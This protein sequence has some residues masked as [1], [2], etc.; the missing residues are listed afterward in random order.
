[1]ARDFID[2]HAA[3]AQFSGPDLENLG[4]RH[5]EDF[6]LQELHDRL[7]GIEYISDVEFEAYGIS[8]VQIA[9]IRRWASA[10]QTS[11]AARLAAD[12]RDEAG[13]PD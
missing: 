10:W 13:Q 4:G 9:L 8:T 11:I 2:I 12:M 7:A 5:D 6:S 3:S 1:M